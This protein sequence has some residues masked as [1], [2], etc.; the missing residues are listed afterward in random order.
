MKDTKYLPILI[1][2]LATDDNNM[3]E[4]LTLSHPYGD[5]YVGDTFEDLQTISKTIML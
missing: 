2:E 1:Y 5:V 4:Q 3:N